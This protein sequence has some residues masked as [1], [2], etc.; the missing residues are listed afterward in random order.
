MFLI[1][2][3]F[4]HNRIFAGK[5]RGLHVEG[6]PVRGSTQAGS[7]LTLKIWTWV[8]VRNTLAYP[9]TESK[10]VLYNRLPRAD[11]I[12]HSSQEKMAKIKNKSFGVFMLSVIR[13]NVVALPKRAGN[14]K[15]ILPPAPGL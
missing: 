15:R 5:A 7:C 13:R 1:V 10:K 8:E 9:D 12:K 3:Y 2:S 11:V 14:A 6:N 4:H